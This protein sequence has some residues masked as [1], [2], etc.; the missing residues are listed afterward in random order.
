MPSAPALKGQS[1]K[2]QADV[3]LIGD[4][5]AVE[6]IHSIPLVTLS[7]YFEIVLSNHGNELPKSIQIDGADIETLKLIKEYAYEGKITGLSTENIEKVEKVA[8]MYNIMGILNECQ[9]FHKKHQ[10]SSV[11]TT[12]S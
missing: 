10:H 5:G 11:H 1:I 2:I 12:K 4:H 6:N 7:P 9:I 3:C 8:D